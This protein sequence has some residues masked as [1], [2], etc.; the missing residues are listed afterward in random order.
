M[1]DNKLAAVALARLIL[2]LAEHV[3]LLPKGDRQPF[4]C[5]TYAARR[6]P[7]ANPDPRS[8]HPLNRRTCGP[9]GTHW[10]GCC[11][12]GRASPRFTEG[13]Y[14]NKVA[15]NGPAYWP[16]CLQFRLRLPRRRLRGLAG[17]AHAGCQR[18]HQNRS[19]IN[20]H[21]PDANHIDDDQVYDRAVH[22]TRKRRSR[23][24]EA[25][26]LLEATAF[27]YDAKRAERAVR[28]I[29]GDFPDDSAQ[30][31]MDGRPPI[32]RDT[33]DALA[34]QFIEQYAKRKTRKNSWR[35]T[36]HVF[37]DIVL[38]AWPGR[39]VHDIARR[40]IREL[41]ERVAEDRPV[42]ANRTLAV[43]GKFFNWACQRDV[44]PASPCVGVARPAEEHARV[45]VLDDAEIRRLWLACEAIGGTAGAC[46]KLLLLTGQRRGEIAHLKWNEVKGNLLE[47][48][49][50]RM[51]GR[52]P[53]VVPLST[54]ASAIIASMPRIGDYVFGQSPVSHFHRIKQQLDAHMGK[55]VPWVVHDLRRTAASGMAKI[56]IAVPTIEKTLAHRSG[57]FRG[58]VGT[59]QRHTFVPEMTVALQ[60]WADHVEGLVSGKPAEDKV[61]PITARR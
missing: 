2:M 27:H 24:A 20:E 3:V 13:G 19:I 49:G 54:Q 14:R 17:W 39:T 33:I 1:D 50:T 56:G 55:R 42:M 40:D 10:D 61:V 41:V 23:Q 37:H 6:H 12:V 22:R 11:L 36:E 34:N 53:H 47:L 26:T 30:Q 8:A 57:T 18:S 38:P 43:L 31:A 48:P 52:Q 59:Y 60:R 35:Q 4:G 5:P 45:R 7:G 28:E 32:A 9:R 46:I 29:A 16:F 15:A 58:I 25:N 44:I 21:H 51:K